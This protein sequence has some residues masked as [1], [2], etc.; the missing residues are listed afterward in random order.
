MAA[1]RADIADLPFWPR[2][3][4][5]DQAAAYV[6]VSPGKFDEE[7]ASGVWP[8]GERRGGRV[9]WDRALLDMAQD[10]RSGLVAPLGSPAHQPEAD[11]WA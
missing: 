11:P 10:A 9:L 1:K 4:S 8:S 3:L 6:G 2:C 5:R 7:V